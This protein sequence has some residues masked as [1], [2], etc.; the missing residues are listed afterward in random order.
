[1]EGRLAK[2]ETL[3]DLDVVVMAIDCRVL[4]EAAASAEMM[5]ELQRQRARALRA[6][7]GEKPE[8]VADL[9][10]A[11]PGVWHFATRVREAA[12]P[13]KWSYHVAVFHLPPEAGTMFVCEGVARLDRTDY[14]RTLRDI[15]TGLTFSG[16]PPGRPG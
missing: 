2:K 13:G 11:K 5:V 10:E 1:V 16:T 15:C 9:A 3:G 4:G 6:F 8:L 12:H 7:A 14:W